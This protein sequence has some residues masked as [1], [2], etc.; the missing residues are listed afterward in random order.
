[1]HPCHFDEEAKS[2]FFC[3]FMFQWM[4]G[5]A[6][7]RTTPSVLSVP[8]LQEVCE[9]REFEALQITCDAS[10][11]KEAKVAGQLLELGPPKKNCIMTALTVLKIPEKKNKQTN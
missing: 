6:M 7:W 8:R 1:M 11:E 4:P 9:P 5:G 10:Q 2:N 3:T